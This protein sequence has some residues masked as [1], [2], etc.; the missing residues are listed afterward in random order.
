[1]WIIW[2]VNVFWLT[3]QM[4]QDQP[5][6]AELEYLKDL[7]YNGFYCFEAIAERPLDS[8]ICGICGI[9]GEVYLGDGNEKNCCSIAKVRFLF[10][11]VIYACT[12]SCQGLSMSFLIFCGSLMYDFIKMFW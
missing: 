5:S 4:L 6:N 11:N 7:L 2:T 10:S 12:S 9:I 3:D 8:V 1:M